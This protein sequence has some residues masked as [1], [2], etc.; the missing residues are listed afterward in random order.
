MRLTV[1]GGSAAGP[2]TGQG[3]SGLLVDTATTRLVIDL[4]PGTLPELRRHADYRSLTGIVVSHLH[5]DHVLDLLALRFALAYNPVPPPRPV[6]LWLPPGGH[7]F[8][9][10]VAAAFADP[11]GAEAFFSAV[12]G[13][14][15]YDPSQTLT[16]G[17]VRLDFAPTV[18]YVSCWA[19]RV[20]SA[21]TR[22]DLVFTGDT[23]PAAGLHSFAAGAAVLV[24][25]ASS[26][27]PD[28]AA[29]AERGHL[30]AREAAE[31][32]NLAGVKTLVLVH[33]WE[34]Y[35]FDSYRRAATAVFP[36]RVEIGRA[37]LCIEW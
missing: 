26:L 15:E 33:L 19:I 30:T 4:G 10:R 3:C 25:E 2:N 1:L 21:D 5:L 13:I 11:D 14:A 8:L 27:D 24:A 22:G 20:S 28:G 9:R 35:G 31:L 23:G 36:G 12:F 37:G 7:E 18:H 34:E 32:G 16:I 6:P 29:P 17:D